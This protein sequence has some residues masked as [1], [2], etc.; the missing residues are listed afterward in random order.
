MFLKTLLH[1]LSVV[2]SNNFSNQSYFRDDIH[3][4]TLSETLQA[5]HFIEGQRA[6]ELC[7]LLLNMAVKVSF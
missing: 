5:C 3:F 2:L 6:V 1:T 4:S 7:D